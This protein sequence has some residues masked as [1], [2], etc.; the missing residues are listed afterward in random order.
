MDELGL[1]EKKGD[2][3][4]DP[5]SAIVQSNYVP[6]DDQFS[7]VSFVCKYLSS[8]PV[9]AIAHG[10]CCLRHWRERVVRPNI[11]ETKCILMT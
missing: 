5:W 3:D 1:G 2:V 8:E 7:R 9:E 4:S 10:R 6:K 11:I